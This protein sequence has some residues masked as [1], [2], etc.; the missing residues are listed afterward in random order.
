MDR[1][2]VDV[3]QAG[4]I[5]AFY[6]LLEDEP[7]IL[8]FIDEVPF[9]R[10]PLHIA[11]LAQ[12][13]HFAKEIAN[14]RPSFITKLDR[15][16]YNPIHLAAEYGQ[17]EM[18]RSLLEISGAA[19][20]AI[21][22]K[23][24]KTPLHFAVMS[25]KIEVV[26]FLLQRYPSCIM[27]LTVK[28]ETVFHL[29]VKHKQLGVLLVLLEQLKLACQCQGKIALKDATCSCIDECMVSINA[30]IVKDLLNCED[31]EGNTVLHLATMM[32]QQQVYI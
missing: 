30:V 21:K 1:R 24:N 25:G 8:N 13:F 5:D 2:L 31:E 10:T 12:K 11:I 17:V 18:V 29:A 28:N 27:D 26:N 22:G 14:I 20:E 15:F 4:N 23:E 19:K 6:A 7:D 16:G 3:S 9:T 32:K